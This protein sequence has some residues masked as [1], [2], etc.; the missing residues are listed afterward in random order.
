MNCESLHIIRIDGSWEFP[1]VNNKHQ[2]TEPTKQK[3]EKK[4]FFLKKK[5]LKINQR[6]KKTHYLQELRMKITLEFSSETM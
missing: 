1:T 3:A 2:T 6:E 4:Y 5:N